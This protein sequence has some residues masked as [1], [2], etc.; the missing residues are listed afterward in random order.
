MTSWCTQSLLRKGNPTKMSKNEEMTT[1]TIAPTNFKGLILIEFAERSQ[2][3]LNLN[4][5]RL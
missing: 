3:D 5:A 4:K 1:T 2:M